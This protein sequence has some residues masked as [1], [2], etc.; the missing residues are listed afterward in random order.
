MCIEDIVRAYLSPTLTKS[1]FFILLITKWLYMMQD[2]ASG[3]QHHVMKNGCLQGDT[4][5]GW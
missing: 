1:S 5:I 4:I 2:Y 3:S